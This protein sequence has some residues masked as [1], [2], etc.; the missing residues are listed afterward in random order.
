MTPLYGASH[1][2]HID[3]AKVLVSHG[4]KIDTRSDVRFCVYIIILVL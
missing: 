3:I 2:G 1:D 4:A